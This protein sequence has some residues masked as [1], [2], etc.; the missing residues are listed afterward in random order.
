MK[1][2][3]KT[4]FIDELYDE[5]IINMNTRIEAYKYLGVR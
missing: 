4:D 2:K 5:G 1:I 3:E